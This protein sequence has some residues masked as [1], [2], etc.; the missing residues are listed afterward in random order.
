MKSSEYLSEAV[1]LGEAELTLKCKQ[2]QGNPQ[3]WVY[4]VT[5]VGDKAFEEVVRLK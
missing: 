1:P 4:H 5:I 2:H 3:H